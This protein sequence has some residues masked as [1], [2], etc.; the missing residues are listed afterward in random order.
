MLNGWWFGVSI[1]RK[2]NVIFSM[3]WMCSSCCRTDESERDGQSRARNEICVSDFTLGVRCFAQPYLS[4]CF[5][6]SFIQQEQVVSKLSFSFQPDP[7]LCFS[8]PSVF[9]S[10]LQQVW[11]T[12]KGSTV[13]Q[14]AHYHVYC[15]HTLQATHT[16][17]HT[18]TCEL[19]GIY[20]FGYRQWLIPDS[21]EF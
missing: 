3:F 6:V 14:Y 13:A 2:G 12:E 16:H 1:T 18:Q 7:L 21:S 15:G 10:R 4:L 8:S 20:I 11:D 9:L 17:P 19:W 5:D